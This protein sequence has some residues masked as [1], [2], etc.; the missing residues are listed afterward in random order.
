VVRAS[1]VASH[2]GRRHAA[3][4]RRGRQHAATAGRHAK[5]S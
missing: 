3:V 1:A 4:G 5:T 2:V